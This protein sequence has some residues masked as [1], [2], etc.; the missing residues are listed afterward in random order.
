MEDN[1]VVMDNFGGVV[2]QALVAVFDGHAGKSVAD[3]LA[4][5]FPAVLLEELERADAEDGNEVG[6]NPQG[7]GEPFS[8]ESCAVPPPAEEGEEE[9]KE[10][11]ETAE[12]NEDGAEDK[13]AAAAAAAAAAEA[14]KPPPADPAIRALVRAFERTDKM[15]DDA[16][17]K[18]GSTAVVALLRQTETEAHL[19]VANAGDARAVLA[20]SGNGV[21][22]SYD[23]KGTDDAERRRVVGCGGFV[24]L[25]RVSG[26]L[27]ISRSF[28][29]HYMKDQVTSQPFITRTQLQPDT[30]PFVIV[31]C[32]G[33]WD[34][35]DDDT[36]VQLALAESTAQ[37]MADRLVAHSLT[38]GTMDNVTC[39]VMQFNQHK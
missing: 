25:G 21:R 36:A 37:E 29:D 28:G 30:D 14:D 9:K 32:D 34:V 16:E 1:Y 8:H 26:V 3:F 22:L 31:A 15:I 17:L 39:C 27:A 7:S 2:G 12:G 13:K 20:R 19:Y 4:E 18:S 24:W 38:E 5:H 23:H 10:D 11:G 33:I 35:I 6:A